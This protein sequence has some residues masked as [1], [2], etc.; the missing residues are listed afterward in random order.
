MLAKY[1][2][3][4][5]ALTALPKGAR[6]FLVRPILQSFWAMVGVAGFAFPFARH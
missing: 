6:Q 3:T 5:P 2:P 1:R 4:D